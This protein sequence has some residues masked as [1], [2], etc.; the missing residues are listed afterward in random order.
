MDIRANAAGIIKIPLL[1]VIFL[2]YSSPASASL[3]ITDFFSDYTSSE[4]TIRSNQDH[5]GKAVFELYDG[6]NVVERQEVPFK[7][8]KVKRFPK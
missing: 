7:T 4:V 1:M 6:I 3:E 2:I 8:G 5:Q